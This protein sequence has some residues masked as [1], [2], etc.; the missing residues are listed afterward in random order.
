MSKMCDV[1]LK[2]SNIEGK[3]IHLFERTKLKGK[4]FHFLMEYNFWDVA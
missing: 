1:I 3:K 2:K 4:F